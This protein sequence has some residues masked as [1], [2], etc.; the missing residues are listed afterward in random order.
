MNTKVQILGI[1]ALQN[2]YVKL[3]KIEVNNLYIA[4]VSLWVLGLGIP[5]IIGIQCVGSVPVEHCIGPF[6]LSNCMT[7]FIID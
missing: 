6:L 5:I 4:M 2:V 1:L 7:W 3:H